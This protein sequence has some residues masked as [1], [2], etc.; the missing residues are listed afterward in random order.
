MDLDKL[1]HI[2][3][4]EKLH[5]D[6]LKYDVDENKIII[7]TNRDMYLLNYSFQNEKKL[8]GKMDNQVEQL[9]KKIQDITIEKKLFE[10]GLLI[11]IIYTAFFILISLIFSLFLLIFCI[12]GL[13]IDI[14]FI[15]VLDKLKDDYKKMKN[16]YTKINRYLN[17]KKSNMK[18]ILSE[19]SKDKDTTNDKSIEIL[20]QKM[21]TIDFENLNLEQLK[22]LSLIGCGKQSE[23]QKIDDNNKTP[24]IK[25]K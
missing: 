22:Q 3:S 24:L 20:S 8:I 11:A 4:V 2:D 18:S 14:K 6:I 21:S 7:L 15:K 16:K 25:T 17:N 10:K 1:S 19:Q 12:P 5:G 13:F 23:L 9:L